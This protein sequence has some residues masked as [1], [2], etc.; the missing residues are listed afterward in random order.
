MGSWE[1]GDQDILA[2]GEGVVEEEVEG[3]AGSKV[4]EQGKQREGGMA[5]GEGVVVVEDEGDNTELVE[6]V[7]EGNSVAEEPRN[8]LAPGTVEPVVDSRIHL[9]LLLLNE[10][11]KVCSFKIQ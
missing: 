3:E 2:V 6:A 5:V 10:N 11:L 7:A 1:L 4:E 8:G 9:K